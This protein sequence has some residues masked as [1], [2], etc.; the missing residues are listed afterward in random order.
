MGDSANME[1]MGNFPITFLSDGGN[2]RMIDFDYVNLL[3]SNKQHSVN[4][5]NWLKSNLRLAVFI[6]CMEL[7]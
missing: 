1:R 6:K 7:K 3:Q 5:E 4:S 2:L